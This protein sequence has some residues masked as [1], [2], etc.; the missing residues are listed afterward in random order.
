MQLGWGRHRIGLGFRLRNGKL[1]IELKHIAHVKRV[2]S[3]FAGLFLFTKK[4][5]TGVK[6]MTVENNHEDEGAFNI[7]VS[8]NV[9]HV[10][11]TSS[12]H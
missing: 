7:S 11:K 6:G 8:F 5:S 2:K 12:L 1:D 4:S 10:T 3:F 9:S